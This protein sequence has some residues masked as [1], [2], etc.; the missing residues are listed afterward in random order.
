[1]SDCRT[2]LANY[3]LLVKPDLKCAIG[4][5]EA[6]AKLSP[7]DGEIKYNYAIAL[8]KD[9]QLE[10]ALENYLRAEELGVKKNIDAL[11][12]NAGGKLMRQKSELPM[13]QEEKEEA[14]ESDEDLKPRGTQFEYLSPEK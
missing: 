3:Y 7:D 6:A 2:N 10:L 11:I 13:T 8:E 12:R 5:L 1:M 9:N 4:H 14:T